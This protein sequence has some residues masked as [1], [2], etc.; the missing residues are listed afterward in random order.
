YLFSQTNGN[1]FFLSQLLR[2]LDTEDRLGDLVSDAPLEIALPLQLKTAIC[3]QVYFLPTG[4]AHILE[5]AAVAGR[6][7]HANDVAKATSLSRRAVAHAM[8]VAVRS[9]VLREAATP[10]A[11]SFNHVLVR[12]AIYD[13]LPSDDRL[14]LHRA[15][16]VAIA[17]DAPSEIGPRAAE[18]A[19]HF[20][21]T[22]AVDGVGTAVKYSEGAA[23]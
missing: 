13:S 20:A 10:G 18:L 8:D 5:V 23:L 11:F 1:P 7:F 14:R 2:V 17:K 16:A 4:I 9:G 3:R 15:I 19:C 12:D 22:V 6:E 21:K